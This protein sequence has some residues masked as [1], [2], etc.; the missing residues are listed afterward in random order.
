MGMSIFLTQND[1]FVLEAVENCISVK[2]TPVHRS[3]A[4][5]QY[6]V[7]LFKPADLS[8]GRASNSLVDCG[9]FLNKNIDKILDWG[10]HVLYQK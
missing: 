7:R 6:R 2:L 3:V 4:T 10:A 8:N 5:I 9:Q 1:F